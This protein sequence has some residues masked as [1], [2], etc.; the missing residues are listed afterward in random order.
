M[1]ENHPWVSAGEV[2]PHLQPPAVSRNI[3]CSN[4][5]AKAD[6]NA[7]VC[8]KCG[9]QLVERSN[10][11]HKRVATTGN[12]LEPSIAVL[13]SLLLV[14][15]P[16]IIMGQAIKGVIMIVVAL[17]LGA[18]TGCIACLVM[19]PISA[20]DAYMIASKLQRGESVG[21]WEFF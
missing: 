9:A 8:I 19:W 17:I 16:Q 21:E 6:S 10:P 5:G 2:Y 18:A 4:C 3:Y 11:N 1:V 15:L 7:V 13:L 12:T 20:I 14:G